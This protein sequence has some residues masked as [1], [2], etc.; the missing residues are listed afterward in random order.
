MQLDLKELTPV[1]AFNYAP[2]HY[3]DPSWLEGLADAKVVK[4][5]TEQPLGIPWASRYILNAYG[6]HGAGDLQFERP[7]KKLALLDQKQLTQI[8]YHAGLALNGPLLRRFIKRQERAAVQACLGER[9]YQYALKK[10]PFLAGDLPERFSSNFVMDWAATAELKKHIFRTGMRLL[11]RVFAR[12]PE[13]F[14]KRLL[15]KFPMPS[16]EYFYAGSITDRT[17][18]DVSRSGEVMLCKLIREFAS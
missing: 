12:E 14:K 7:V 9:G 10:G 15:F 18:D 8:V 6:L 2:A 1:L 16:K 3:I 4:A 13:C 17:D 11:G 5:L